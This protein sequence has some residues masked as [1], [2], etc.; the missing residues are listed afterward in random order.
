MYDRLMVLDDMTTT[1]G[2]RQQ[3]VAPP[4]GAAMIDADLAAGPR[5]AE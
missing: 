3:S 5:R 2:V 4:A 1:T